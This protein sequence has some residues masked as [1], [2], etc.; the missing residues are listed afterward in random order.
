MKVEKIK[1]HIGATV[2]VDAASLSDPEVISGC[3][4]LLEDRGVVVF[5]GLN[6]T[7]DQQLAFTDSLGTQGDG[8]NNF[9]GANRMGEKNVFELSLDL[10]KETQ[11]LYVKT[12]YFWHFDGVHSDDPLPK[13]TL[14]SA[15]RI[16]QKG[17]LTE[18]ANTYCAYEQL[19]D[20]EKAEI[21]EL[22]ALHTP[23]AGLRNVLESPNDEERERLQKLFP[24]KAY[25]IVWKHLSGRSSL[26]IGITADYV[27]GLPVPE[28]RAL[29]SRLLEWTVQ[30]EFKYTHRWQV[31]D[32]VLWN[33]HTTLH[34]ATP[35]DPA[36]GRSMLRTSFE[37][38]TERPIGV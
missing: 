11:A 19:P 20:D 8:T 4:E 3:L 27:V 26:N 37:S 30:P 28:G 15:R 32:L 23:I 34:R 5:P 33:N 29:L 25:P 21:D 17:G 2:L 31:G 13:G 10:S 38:G 12:S 1:P 9:P 16:S 35:Y 14:L 22:R 24:S 36:S 7:P 6:L 18:F